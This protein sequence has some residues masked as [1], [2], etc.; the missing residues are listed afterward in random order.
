MK[1]TRHSF[2]SFIV[3]VFLTLG[4]TACD[5][6][7]DDLLQEEEYADTPADEL[8]ANARQR[9]NEGDY[10][11]AVQLFDEVERQHPYS[12]WAAR[13]Q[14]MAGF[15]QYRQQ[16]YDDA[17]LTFDR[18]LKLHPGSDSAAYASYMI[19]LSYYEQI[20]DVGRDQG[21][22]QRARESLREVVKRYPDTEFARDAR[23]KLDLTESHLAGKEMMVGRYYLE[24]GEY[25]SAANRFRH[26][27]DEYQTTSHVAEALHRLVET[28]LKLGVRAEAERYA[29]VLGHNFS[30]SEWYR[31]SYNLMKKGASIPEPEDDSMWDI[32]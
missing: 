16:Q 15:T 29:A 17:I 19:A 28:Y 1:S 4:V 21:M 23:L 6:S 14:V 20:S 13:S 31:Y 22:T 5:S 32:F 25:L 11:E 10:R 7:D 9:L 27:V 26:V 3:I 30:G 2:I 8:Y 18:F 12:D 24:Q